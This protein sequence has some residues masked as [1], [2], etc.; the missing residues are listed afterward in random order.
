M[1]IMD[2]AARTAGDGYRLTAESAMNRLLWF[3]VSISGF[4]GGHNALL[5]GPPVLAKPCCHGVFRTFS[6]MT[7]E[8]AIETAAG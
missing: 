7:F 3:G 5:I 1:I 2:S 8:E 6:P 4:A